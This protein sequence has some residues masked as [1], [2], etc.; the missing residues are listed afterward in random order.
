MEMLMTLLVNAGLELPPRIVYQ[1]LPLPFIMNKRW[2]DA[3]PN[4]SLWDENY[5]LLL[6]ETETHPRDREEPR[7]VASAIGAFT[8]DNFRRTDAGLPPLPSKRYIGITMIKS[9]PRLYKITI[10]QSLVDAVKTAQTPV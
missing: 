4:F 9:A 2:F 5:V 8:E 10:T 3:I 6:V 1:R 7:L